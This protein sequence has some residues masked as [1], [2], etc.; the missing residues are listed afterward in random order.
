MT[1]TCPPNEALSAWLDDELDANEALRIRRH[2]E[3]CAACREQVVGWMEAVPNNLP[4]PLLGKEGNRRSKVPPPCQG[5]GQGEVDE[6]TRRIFEGEGQAEG[7]T[8]CLDEETLVAY[9]EAELSAVEAAHAEQHLRQ[10]TRCVSEVQRLIHLR[11][12][13]ESLLQKAEIGS[14]ASEERVGVKAISSL[15]AVGKRPSSSSLS[16]WARACP[17]LVEGVGVRAQ[18]LIGRLRDWLESIGRIRVQPWPALGAVAATALLVL[19]IVRFLPG[20]ADVQFRGI[21]GPVKVQIITDSAIARARPSDAEP[22]IATLG[23]GTQATRL[24]QSGEWTRIE[25][26]DGGRVWVRS[27]DVKQL[28]GSTP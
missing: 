15:P 10:C 24:E 3:S 8:T 16:L 9:S 13:M 11:T 12:A 20:G 1:R 18:G 19:V 4:L 6:V 21:P 22:I 2:V 14:L 5:G 17:E 23:R 7:A 27:H 25:L 26:P 28:R